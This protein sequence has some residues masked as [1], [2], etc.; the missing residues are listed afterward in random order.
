MHLVAPNAGRTAGLKEAPD[1]VEP[2]GFLFLCTAIESL[3]PLAMGTGSLPENRHYEL[4]L[5]VVVRRIHLFELIEHQVNFSLRGAFRTHLRDFEF[6]ACQHR[7][8]YLQQMAWI[9]WGVPLIASNIDALA[10]D[11]VVCTGATP[12]EV[13]CQ[14]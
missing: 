13:H 4:A 3:W 14:V 1:R 10:R 8:D 7:L 12:A 6:E 2:G 11:E 5:S 9:H